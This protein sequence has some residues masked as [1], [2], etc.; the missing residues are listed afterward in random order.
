[1]DYIL[2]AAR[3]SAAPSAKVCRALAGLAS[4]LA[5]AV[6]PAAMAGLHGQQRAE[7]GHAKHD[8]KQY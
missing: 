3:P 6:R 1:M 2:F 5:L 4:G 7:G 8:A